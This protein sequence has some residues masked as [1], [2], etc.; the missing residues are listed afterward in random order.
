MPKSSEEFLAQ[1]N[2]TCEK[3][4][5]KKG[6]EAF[7]V[8]D[9]MRNEVAK[10]EITFYPLSDEESEGDALAMSEKGVPIIR[11]GKHFYEL[12]KLDQYAVL[13]HE[14]SHIFCGTLDLDHFYGNALPEESKS[15]T[16]HE[17]LMQSVVLSR[18]KNFKEMCKD[19]AKENDTDATLSA[20][21]YEF[22]LHS[23]YARQRKADEKDNKASEIS[24]GE[25]G[26]SSDDLKGLGTDFSW[27]KEKATDFIKNP[28]A[29]ILSA[30]S[31]IFGSGSSTQKVISHLEDYAGS[32][33]T[34]GEDEANNLNSGKGE[35]AINSPNLTHTLEES[36]QTGVSSAGI[37][38][39]LPSPPTSDN[40]QKPFAPTSSN[41]STSSTHITNSNS[42]I[43]SS[44]VSKKPNNPKKKK[45]KNKIYK[46]LKR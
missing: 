23:M 43:P 29:P 27:W 22:S 20:Y 19:L 46:W 21:N 40:T 37:L 28:T 35:E 4:F 7:S 12:P 9:K 1:Y 25:K 34:S 8:F 42:F 18:R 33:F 5:G 26:L 16:S 10:N 39:S 36:N 38:A 44:T 31:K 11:L 15:H 3:Y 32:S 45:R 14:L 41:Q 13:V 24:D 2:R 30:I 6:E 17:K